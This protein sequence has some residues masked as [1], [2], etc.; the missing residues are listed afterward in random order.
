MK[1]L[2]LILMIGPLQVKG[3]D[4]LQT[5]KADDVKREYIVHLPAHFDKTKKHALVFV[6]HGAKKSVPFFGMNASSA[7]FNVLQII[8]T[9]VFHT[10][11][12]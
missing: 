12:P 11:K 10:F 4:V 8:G 2:L 3:Q 6:F 1:A 7:S 5:I 9:I